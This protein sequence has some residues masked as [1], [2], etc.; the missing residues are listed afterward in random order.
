[1]PTA[2]PVFIVV[3]TAFLIAVVV[4]YRFARGLIMRLAPAPAARRML[5]KSTDRRSTAVTH[6]ATVAFLDLIG[7]TSI[8][9]KVPPADFNSLLNTYFDRAVEN[10]EKHRG[11]IAAFT[12]DGITAIFT[13]TERRQ[14]HAVRACLAVT[15]VLAAMERV[16]ADNAT[17]G[18]PA[19]HMR[20]GMNSGEV[21]E[22]EIGARDRFN[23]SVIG[24][25]VN[26]AS[27][28]EQMGKTLFPGENDVVLL[29]ET[30]HEMS[31]GAGFPFRDCGPCEI[32]GRDRPERV[33]RLELPHRG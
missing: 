8:A 26:L 6:D 2:T 5:T 28:L 33:F 31:V 11:Q 24:D 4:R 12:G 21:V 19:L 20:I 16:N 7:S 3:P 18:L 10:V 15:D 23:F 9:E 25:V 27:R 17:L 30:T 29:G 32:R 22:G 14:N 1:M 13:G